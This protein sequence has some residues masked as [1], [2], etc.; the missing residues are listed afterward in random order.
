MANLKQKSYEMRFG[1]NNTI[2][3]G[4]YKNTNDCFFEKRKLP[5]MFHEFD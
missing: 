4:K 3:Q 5:Q 2:S 1:N